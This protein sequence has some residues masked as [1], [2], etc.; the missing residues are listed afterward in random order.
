MQEEGK[1]TTRREAEMW[2]RRA[3]NTARKHRSV[4]PK[5]IIKITI[6]QPRGEAP[7]FPA[8]SKQVTS[9]DLLK[10][11]IN[12]RFTF[13]I[14]LTYFASL[15]I[16]SPCRASGK[17]ILSPLSSILSFSGTP[18]P[19]SV[20]IWD[21]RTAYV[22]WTLTRW[23]FWSEQRTS[24]LSQFLCYVGPDHECMDQVAKAAPCL[25][26]GPYSSSSSTF[27]AD[28][29]RK[30][31]SFSGRMVLRQYPHI[32]DETPTL[33]FFLRVSH[34]L[35]QHQCRLALVG[36]K[37]GQVSVV[38]WCFERLLSTACR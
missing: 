12:S 25:R 6:K 11:S 35:F 17:G 24:E 3:S 33:L 8:G 23:T 1:L 29:H 15:I 26:F 18:P 31:D 20:D 36:R 21:R 14:G 5:N 22:L 28:L 9:N 7:T 2:K 16:R 4:D 37:E 19:M 27:M 34:L 10:N 30:R 32:L 38:P 13:G